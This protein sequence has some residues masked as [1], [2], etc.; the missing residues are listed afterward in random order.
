VVGVTGRVP[1]AS[2]ASREPPL[3]VA[4]VLTAARVALDERRLV[5]MDASALNTL[6]GARGAQLASPCGSKN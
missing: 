4:V 3:V 6:A 5:G 2:I 1:K